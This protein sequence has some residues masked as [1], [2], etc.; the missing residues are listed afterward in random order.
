M[1]ASPLLSDPTR[2][3]APFEPSPT[4]AWDLLQEAVIRV[5]ARWDDLKDQ[6]P[7]GYASTVMSRLNVDR[8]RRA[9][10]VFRNWRQVRYKFRIGECSVPASSSQFNFDR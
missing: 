2:A 5:A 3:W 10:M 9:R 7:G 1:D 4:D 6:N 8:F